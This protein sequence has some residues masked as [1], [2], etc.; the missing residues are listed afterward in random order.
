MPLSEHE[1][2]M[3]DDLERRLHADDPTFARGFEGPR[4]T[5][6]RRRQLLGLIALLAGLALLILAVEL[7]AVWLGVLAFV[8]MLGGGL[9]AV[10]A[11]E[12]DPD[13]HRT[14]PQTAGPRAPHP[15]GGAQRPTNRGFV[16]RMEQ[17]WERRTEDDRGL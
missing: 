5:R 3:L 7:S 10:T 17:R 12:M 14:A 8:L 1:Q 13:H 15:A 6:D 4:P 9:I 16:Q 2:R 11:P